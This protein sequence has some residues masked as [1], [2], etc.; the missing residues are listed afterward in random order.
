MNE[1]I[2]LNTNSFDFVKESQN[3]L[4]EFIQN[5]NFIIDY[6]EKKWINDKINSLAREII[7]ICITSLNIKKLDLKEEDYEFFKIQ[8]KNIKICCDDLLDWIFNKNEIES[9]YVNIGNSNLKNIPNR[10]LK[11]LKYHHIYNL[12]NELNENNELNLSFSDLENI[13]QGIDFENVLS[14]STFDL[15]N[16][17]EF[18][19]IYDEID[20]NINNFRKIIHHLENIINFIKKLSYNELIIYDL[21]EVTNCWRRIKKLNEKIIEEEDKKFNENIESSF[22]I[23]ST[24][25]LTFFQLFK[26]EEKNKNTSLIISNKNNLIDLKKQISDNSDCSSFKFFF[27]LNSRLGVMLRT[28]SFFYGIT[29]LKSSDN[30][31]VPAMCILFGSSSIFYKCCK[32][33]KKKN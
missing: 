8:K 14:R 32:K 2:E 19:V 12:I 15:L 27:P 29:N 1:I 5:Y 22:N 11:Q 33:K 21:E 31:F 26:K 23:N 7:S 16:N 10:T 18:T 3:I 17:D 28:F 4:Y 30:K 6:N 20:E 13:K 24:F 25:P 9:G